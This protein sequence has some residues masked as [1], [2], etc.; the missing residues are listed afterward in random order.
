MSQAMYSS[1][2]FFIWTMVL[3]G[4][5]A[6]F[7]ESYLH[8]HFSMSI[9]NTSHLSGLAIGLVLGRLRWFRMTRYAEA[10]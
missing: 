2:L 7:L 10:E 6:F 8:Y 4:G 9:A 1:L 5:A 3:L